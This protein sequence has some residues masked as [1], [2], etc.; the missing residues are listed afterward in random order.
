[1]HG[2]G[3]HTSNRV[4]FRCWYTGKWHPGLNRMVS[5]HECVNKMHDNV[6]AS[7]SLETTITNKMHK[8]VLIILNI[9]NKM[10]DV[11]DNE[12]PFC[13]VYGDHAFELPPNHDWHDIGTEPPKRRTL[14]E[15]LAFAREVE[16]MLEERKTAAAIKRLITETGVHFMSPF[17]KLWSGF[18]WS[19]S[20][21]TSR[22][23]SRS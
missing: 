14:E 17:F 3:K 9:F 2:F 1:M 8:V 21:R 16:R 5:A 12:R 18:S 10:W 13:Q 6:D 11:V 22:T 19:R 20:A 15:T 4:C 7:T 23:L